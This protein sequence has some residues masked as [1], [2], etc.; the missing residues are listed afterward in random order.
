VVIKGGRVREFVPVQAQA[1]QVL[2]EWLALQ[3]K[4]K[5]PLFTTRTGQ[6]LT[7]Y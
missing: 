1:R 6:Q 5:G 3:P 7:R 4:K 2:A